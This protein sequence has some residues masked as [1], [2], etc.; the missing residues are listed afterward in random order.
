M[1]EGSKN[2]E[3]SEHRPQEPLPCAN[4]CG[5]FGSP[6]TRNLKC[7]RDSLRHAEAQ[8]A[9]AVVAVP[10][11]SSPSDAVPVEPMAA[12][13]TAT[14]ATEE[15]KEQSRCAASGRKVGLMGFECHGCGY[16]YRGAGRDAISRANPVVRTDKQVDKL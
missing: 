8:T 2:R 4:N 9:T 13:A 16:D 5:F 11:A 15:E 3:A 1:E 7:F 6:A 14:T 10:S 12:S